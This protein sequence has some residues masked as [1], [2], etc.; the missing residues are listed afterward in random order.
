MSEKQHLE[1]IDIPLLSSDI[2]RARQELSGTL[3]R[4][5]A[6]KNIQ[7]ELKK[8]ILDAQVQKNMIT[9]AGGGSSYVD[10]F[11]R[12]ERAA[13][14]F[15]LLERSSGLQV[16]YENSSFTVVKRGIRGEELSFKIGESGE[17]YEYN[18]ISSSVKTA[19]PEVLTKD[20]LFARE[21]LPAFH[22]Q[23]LKYFR[24]I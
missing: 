17:E 11:E 20:I 16:K 13:L 10:V 19:M 15:E 2:E 5:E 22:T 24:E 14:T 1:E 12:L 8:R 3:E 6:S 18:L 23:V 21:M 9:L 4:L 7:R